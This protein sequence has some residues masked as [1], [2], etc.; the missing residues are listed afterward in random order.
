MYSSYG[1]IDYK[2]LFIYVSMTHDVLNPSAINMLEK[3]VR[4]F[5]M[6]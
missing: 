5:R 6:M 1:H 2:L 4:F 3:H